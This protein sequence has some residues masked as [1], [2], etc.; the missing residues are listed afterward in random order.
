MLLTP[1]HFLRQEQYFESLNAWGMRYL[2]NGSGLVGGG[3][4]LPESDLGTVRFDPE[5]SL[6][7]TA[8]YLDISVN[9][10]RGVTPSGAIIEV[11]SAGTISA[12]FPKNELAGVAESMIFVVLDP[13]SREKRSG[14]VDSFNPQMRTERVPS[15]RVALHV[16]AAERA[17]SVVVGRLRRPATARARRLPR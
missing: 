6:T 2:L 12:R 11:E 8:D 10:A 9:R 13:A 16:T 17:Q 15:Y 14:V 7:E 5:V 1:D 3:V 4:R